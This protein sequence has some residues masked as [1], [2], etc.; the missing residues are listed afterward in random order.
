MKFLFVLV[1]IMALTWV[2]QAKI[3]KCEVCQ[4]VVHGIE[5][6]LQQNKTAD[7][8]V[9][10]LERTCKFLPKRHVAQCQS[11]IETHTPAIIA[12]L[13]TKDHS[14]K[15]CSKLH[16]C[17]KAHLREML[18]SDVSE[19][20]VSDAEFLVEA[21]YEDETFV[22]EMV[23]AE[24]IEY[25]QE[26]AVAE[27]DFEETLLEKKFRPKIK[28]PKIKFLKKY[29]CKAC[30]HVAK[31]IEKAVTSGKAVDAA[32][33]AGEASCSVFKVHPVIKLCKSVVHKVVHRMVD[34]IKRHENPTKGKF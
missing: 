8:I 7:Q 15:I 26:D 25:V 21:T 30:Q 32:T 28:I 19:V 6:Q 20:E 33:H 16:L 22:S 23:D 14:L 31:H 4:V 34:S 10:Q 13:A 29:G 5:H 17:K 27:S 1:A 11:I 2:A 3:N 9:H 24:D 18:E 12:R